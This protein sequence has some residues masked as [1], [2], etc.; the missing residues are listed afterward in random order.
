[1]RLFTSLWWYIL[2]FVVMAL[3]VLIGRDNSLY[4][5]IGMSFL[6]I[7]FLLGWYFQSTNK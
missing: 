6:V 4:A 3:T 5:G 1:M 2:L 7:I